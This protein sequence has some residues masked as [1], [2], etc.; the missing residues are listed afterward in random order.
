M[1][2]NIYLRRWSTWAVDA[3]ERALKTLAQTLALFA[4]G[5]LTDLMTSVEASPTDYLPTE[6]LFVV[7]VVMAALS[8]LTSVLSKKTGSPNSAAAFN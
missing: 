1:T 2:S 7:P 8:V 4:V 6:L 5:A 3:A